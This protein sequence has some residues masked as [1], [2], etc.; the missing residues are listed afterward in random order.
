MP[1]LHA[2]GGPAL[3]EL[4]SRLDDALSRSGL[5]KTQL[6]ARAA[7]S[8]TTVQL[9]FQS[10]APVASAAT[11]TALARVLRL[12]DHEL[13]DLR[14][15]ATEG[16]AVGREEDQGLGKPIS[17][18]DPHDLEIHPAGPGLGEHAGLG[19]SR[20]S[21]PGYV[22]RHHDQLL[23]GVVADAARGRSRMLVLVGSSSTGK[24]R[25][26]WEAIRPLADVGW[27]LWHPSSPTRAEAALEDLHRVRPRTVVWLNETQHY[28]GE[29]QVGERVAAGLHQLA[30]SGR[31][32]FLILGT[33]WPE[34]ADQYTVLPSPGT[35]D[36]H[37]RAR[38]LLA[39]RMV[40]VPEVFDDDALRDATALAKNGDSLL[41]D[42]LTRA[43][44]HGRMT[45]DLAGAPELLRRYEHGTP[46]V[47]ALLN[48]AMDARR[49]GVP[50]HLPQAFLTDA[51]I[52]YFDGQDLDQLDL[53]WAEAAFADLAR[54]VHGRQPPVRRIGARPTHR[55]PGGPT[56]VVTPPTVRSP[57]FRLAD[58][59]EQHGRTIR[60]LL[61][62]P[63][64]FWHAAHRHLTDS[65]ALDRLAAEADRR[66]RRQWAYHLR[67]RAADENSA[68]ATVALV[69][70]RH[71]AGDRDGAEA[72]AVRA[73]EAGYPNALGLLAYLREMAGDRHG[74]EALFRQAGAAGHAVSLISLAI[75]LRR[76]GDLKGAES[77]YRQAAD[78]GHA[79]VLPVLAEMREEAGDSDG[80]TALVVSEAEAG[81]VW[82]LYM[83]AQLREN[84][85]DHAGARALATRAA[86]AGHTFA[87]SSLA[88]LRVAAGDQE[89]AEAL[90]R[91]AADAGDTD[92]LA[93]LAELR[94]AAG[95]KENAEALYRQAADAGRTFALSSLA[96]LRVA[97][98]DQ[99]GAE[100]LYRQAADAG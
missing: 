12:P 81:D 66:E 80:A 24:S 35:P 93:K 61:C 67:L 60:R 8:R 31:G 91:Q 29:P 90:Y 89:G 19:A 38:E 28:L 74:A 54:P 26:C 2:E 15:A 92:A 71:E 70:S 100:A 97:A 88:E 51:A 69:R 33:L 21:L 42:A 77:L 49:L 86:D 59:L 4:R 43:R 40:T 45:Q 6:A 99:E 76:E 36:L 79:E 1:D 73:A 32:P 20:R 82:P 9:A 96:E 44:V 83:L 7:V 10:D 62:P 11:L 37:S 23:A 52:D 27:R 5:T 47:R 18:W 85:G 58:Y 50:L 94:M 95:D 41:A 46:A 13:L 39:G 75:T 65:D 64:S 16:N 34:Y 3:T 53:D 78:A 57:A 56:P 30:H 72:L 87:L 84:A 98:G 17:Q 25:A 63:A 55:Y 48:A 14:R 68:E 22:A